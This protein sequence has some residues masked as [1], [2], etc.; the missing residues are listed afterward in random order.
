MRKWYHPHPAATAMFIIGIFMM[1][2]VVMIPVGVM[3]IVIGVGIQ[4]ASM[5]RFQ[6]LYAK[7]A[8]QALEKR[9]REIIKAFK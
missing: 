7:A 8:E 5:R 9:R 2:T 3:F 6:K 1:A 4:R